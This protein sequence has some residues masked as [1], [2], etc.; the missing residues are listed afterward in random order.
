MRR[1]VAVHLRPEQHAPRP[2]AD[3]RQIDRPAFDRFG[4]LFDRQPAA[5]RVGQF[6]ED[7]LDVASTQRRRIDRRHAKSI[8]LV[9][10]EQ[11]ESAFRDRYLLAGILAGC[12]A[13]IRPR[14]RANTRIRL[15]P[16]MPW[17]CSSV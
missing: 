7:A 2:G 16:R 17:I 3:R 8:V 11:S 13:G 6:L 1:L 14:R 5:G 10:F 15:P 12:F 4:K 9:A